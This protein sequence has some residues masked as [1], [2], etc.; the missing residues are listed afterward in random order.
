M[1]AI[2][3]TYVDNWKDFEDIRNWA[4]SV[5]IVT[6]DYGNKLIPYNWLYY[7]DLKHNE[8]NAWQMSAWEDAKKRYDKSSK[9]FNQEDYD[10]MVECDG[11]DFLE[12]PENFFELPIWNTDHIEDIY[13][14]RYCPLEIIQNRLKQQYGGGWSK[15]AL[16]PN[17]DRRDYESIKNRTSVYDTYKREYRKNI[18]FTIHDKEPS[19][20]FKDDDI[21]WWIQPWKSSGWNYDDKVDKWYS[22]L[23]CYYSTSNWITNTA[24]LYGNMSKRRLARIIQ[25]WNLPA[26]VQLRFIGDHKRYTVADFIIT[27]K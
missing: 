15:I 18:H 2:D 25:K 7:P 11:E 23:E 4:K 8:F 12:H 21:V 27:I 6:D 19:S 17:N 3:K 10:Y 14:I 26:G 9:D 13:L 1:A 22:D 20:K 16:I 24:H 5:G